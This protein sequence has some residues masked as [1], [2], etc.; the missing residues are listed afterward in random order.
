MTVKLEE[1][2]YL[3]HYGTKRHSGRYPWGSGDDDLEGYGVN[4]PRNEEFLQRVDSMKKKGMSEKEIADGV[5][6]TMKDLRDTKSNYKYQQKATEIAFMEKLKAKGY[7]NKAIG[8]R[9]GK[10]ESVV[11]SYLAPGAK[12]KLEATRATTNMLKS[13][14]DEKGMV[15]VGA[16]VE[17]RMGI[18]RTKLEQALSALK[19]Q[20]Y[21]VHNVKQPQIQTGHETVQKVLATPG[22]TQHDVFMNKSQVQQ[23]GSYSEDNGRSIIRIHPPMKIDPVRLDVIYGDEGKQADGV[24]YVRPDVADLSLGGVNYSQVRIR[25][26]DNHYIKGMAMYKADLP[27][28]VDLQFNT[29]KKDTGNHLDALKEVVRGE[30]GKPDDKNPFGAYIAHQITENSGSPEEKLTSAMNV[31]NEEGDWAEWSR[32]LS[33]Q[34][35]SKQKPKLAKTQL[36]MTYERRQAEHKAINELTNDTVKKKLLE[37]FAGATDT[38]A[39]H[40]KAAQLPRQANHV[41]LPIHDMKPTEVYAPRFLDGET[42]VLIRF[43]HGGTFEIPRLIV[44]NKHETARRLI[45]HDSPDA[46]GIHSSVAERLSGADFDG[47]TVL[48]VPDNNKRI[49]DTKALDGLKNFDPIAEYPGYPGMKV[50]GNTQAQMGMISNLITDMSLGGAGPDE[51]TRAVKHSMVVIDAEKKQLDHSR[52]FRDNNIA[53]LKKRYQQ[54]GASTLISRKG[55]PL[56]VPERKP[57]TAAKGGPVNKVTGELMYEPTNKKRRDGTPLMVRVPSLAEVKD[58]HTLSS[59]TP[60]ETLYADHSNRLKAMANRARL[61]ALNTPA[62]KQ[63]ASA[64]K[65]YAKEVE[66]LE[67]SLDIAY[68]NRPLERH[69]NIVAD[70]AIRV[71]VQAN[72]N[73]E[74]STRKKIER[75]ELEDARVRVGAKA[76]QINISDDEWK[77]IQA[78]AVSNSKLTEILKYADPKR[79]RELATPQTA[80]LMTPTKTKRANDMIELGYTHAEI[81]SSLGVSVSTLY[82]A[83]K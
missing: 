46:I 53:G 62:P 13:E 63:S 15:D 73:M 50:M 18:T 8:D 60:M 23:I 36:D 66:S 52:S 57:R 38:A 28:G 11:R 61:D 55:R 74:P 45:G 29:A 17:N 67:A 59:G 21:E 78:N 51:L 69:A 3:E 58:A 44:N 30:D 71:R 39:A 82:D 54:G 42:V 64:K 83:L 24:V 75:Q 47:D 68:R 16:G 70:S 79:V 14:V 19:D 48:V 22:T 77:A 33:S 32:T 20:G 26:G 80:R 7:S 2:Q 41:I 6:M 37:D 1:E 65:A 4:Y 5:G 9:M 12:D 27:P 43:P 56:E 49:N 10:A 35:L 31:V 25:V 76:H 81:A 34:F 72:P 40:L